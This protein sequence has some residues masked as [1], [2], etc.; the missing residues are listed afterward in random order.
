[1]TSTADIWL[2]LSIRI[3]AFDSEHSVD[4]CPEGSLLLWA[5]SGFLVRS[6]Y[7]GYL[8]PHKIFW[9]DTGLACSCCIFCLF[10]NEIIHQ[11][12]VRIERT[13]GPGTTVDQKISRRLYHRDFVSSV[14]VP[15]ASLVCGPRITKRSL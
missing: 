7:A 9:V 2:R 4:G 1:M 10:Q 6:L 8:N 14:Q 13:I 15:D 12:L 5:K 3:L 11:P